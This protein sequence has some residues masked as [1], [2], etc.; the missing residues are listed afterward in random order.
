MTTSTAQNDAKQLALVA[1]GAI[2][3]AILGVAITFLLYKQGVRAAAIPGGLLGIGAGLFRHRTIAVPIICCI[4]ALAVGTFVEWRLFPFEKDESLAYFI[5]HM[6]DKRGLILIMIAIGGVVGF[7]SPFRSMT[8][9][10]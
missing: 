5:T 9:R 7:Y 10:A 6:Q 1:L 4:A 2:G 8:S 3:G